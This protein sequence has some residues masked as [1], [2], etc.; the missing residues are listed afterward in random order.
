MRGEVAYFS[1]LLSICIKRCRT[2]I[3][4]QGCR[5]GNPLFALDYIKKWLRSHRC[6]SD[7]QI[8]TSTQT[9]R[10]KQED[11]VLKFL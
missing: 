2:E 1:F 8:R 3:P 7:T 6:A 11:P 9:S 10:V 4:T 5:G